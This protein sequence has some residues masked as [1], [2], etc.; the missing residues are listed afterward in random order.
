MQSM[1]ITAKFVSLNPA[2]GEVYSIQHYKSKGTV[3]LL[4]SYISVD[5]IFNNEHCISGVV[6]VSVLASSAV[7]LGFEPGRVKPKTIKLVFVASSLS[8]QL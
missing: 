4:L 8:M 2:H 5:S 1:P 3:L 6:M 7:D